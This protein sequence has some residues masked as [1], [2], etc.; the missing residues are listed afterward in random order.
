M[1]QGSC[2]HGKS[3]LLPEQGA[4]KSI[5]SKKLLIAG[6]WWGALQPSL[7]RFPLQ[8]TNKNSVDNFK[9]RHKTTKSTLRLK[10]NLCHLRHWNKSVSHP[11]THKRKSMW[12][13]KQ[14]LY[15]KKRR[16]DSFKPS[17]HVC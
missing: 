15:T 14:Q 11:W 10:S 5:T 12:N 17:F 2:W 6:L 1:W 16:L 7:D 8:L 3:S 13:F 4:L 9:S